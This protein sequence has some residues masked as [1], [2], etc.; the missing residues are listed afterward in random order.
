MIDFNDPYILLGLLP[1]LLTVAM[2]ALL[3]F[4]M[5]EGLGNT[6]ASS[7]LVVAFL[8]TLTIYAGLPG[9]PASGQEEVLTYLCLFSLLY[10]FLLDRFPG[11]DA[12]NIFFKSV[13]P[14]AGVFWT[15]SPSD[16]LSFSGAEFR[17]LA[18]VTI[19]ALGYF[20][21]ME[22]DWQDGLD[23]ALPLCAVGLGGMIIAWSDGQGVTGDILL[24]YVS[25]LAGYTI[26]NLPKRRF[27]LGAA[28]FFPSFLV[29]LT[30]LLAIV[31]EK[32]S[33]SPAIILLS[34]IMMADN[35]GRHLPIQLPYQG[36]RAVV[37]AGLLILSVAAANI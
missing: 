35:I 11:L 6:L 34:L 14:V 2:M 15:F 10:G 7:S 4:Y 30:C 5:G 8:V 32:P 13:I 23:L 31:M 21:K 1:F 25:A 24:A 17:G 28:G 16:A 37:I 29:I 18:L 9:W 20:L 12:A 22:Q 27:P 26:L 33:L 36:K 3:R 19:L